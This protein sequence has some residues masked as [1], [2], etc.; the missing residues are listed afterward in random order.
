MRN[1][2]K[3]TIG[4]LLTLLFSSCKK[5][6][7]SFKKINPTDK[8]IGYYLVKDSIANIEYQIFFDNTNEKA[9]EEAIQH[10]NTIYK[11]VLKHYITNNKKLDWADVAI[12]NN[13][14]Y[15]APNSSQ[16]TRWIIQNNSENLSLKAENE[17]H[18]LIS[19]EQ[20]HTWQN[21]FGS[22]ESTPRWF[23][24]GIALWAEGKITKKL[25][26]EVFKK[27]MDTRKLAYD[28]VIEKDGG[29]NLVSWGGIIVL[30]EVIRR[31][32]T[33][34]GQKY[35]DETGKTP[36]SATVNITPADMTQDNVNH[37]A[38]YYGAYLLFHKL[39]EKMGEEKLKKWIHSTVNNSNCDNESILNDLE[40]NFGIDL[41]EE[42]K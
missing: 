40:S 32:L 4:I 26:P 30:P 38:R 13:K 11:E 22:C 31:Q 28:K 9:A 12:V 25:K 23:N 34:E 2:N 20:V 5:E 42:L 27:A 7:Y 29:L 35:F 41:T 18:K 1:L 24:E 33:P 10:L 14:D 15:K 19:H 21:Q 39:E 3:V 36:K 8:E 16:K 17:I 6:N 37:P